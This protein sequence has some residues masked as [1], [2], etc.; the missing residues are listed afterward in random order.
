MP[1]TITS[2]PG[3]SILFGEHA[4]VY[5]Y[6]AIAVPLDSISFKIKLLPRPTENNSIIINEELG[7]SLIFENLDMQHTYRTAIAA[8]LNELRI[9][10]LPP[11]EIRLS[12]TIPIASGLGSSASFAVC[13]VKALSAFLG[14][15]LSNKKVNEIAYQI[16]I[17][18]HGTPSGIDNTVI[19]YNKPVFF[20]KGFPPEFLKIGAPLNLVIADT[21]VRSITKETVAQVRKFMESAPSIA[22]E[23]IQKIGDVVGRAKNEIENGNSYAIG[24]LMTENHTLLKKLGVSCKELDYLVEVSLNEGAVGAKLCGSGRGGNIVA[25]CGAEKTEHIKIALLKN[26][27]PHSFISKIKETKDEV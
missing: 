26:G 6:P 21:G 27:S 20:K 13:L 14:F 23:T 7:E 10:K 19:T 17:F 5:G 4:V 11:L 15:R 25:L 22:E 2:A 1:S 3:K 8:I 12:S 16:E 9:S 24:S 18:Q